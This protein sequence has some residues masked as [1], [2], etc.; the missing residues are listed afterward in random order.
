MV[1]GETVTKLSVTG[2]SHVPVEPKTLLKIIARVAERMDLTIEAAGHTREGKYIFALCSMR[3]MTTVGE[4]QF[5]QYLMISTSNEGNQK[6]RITPLCLNSKLKVQLPVLLSQRPTESSVNISHHYT[7]DADEV[8]IELM[9]KLRATHLD[10][11]GTL[12][13]LCEMSASTEDVK[14]FHHMIY[15]RFTVGKSIKKE[16]DAAM[17]ELMECYKAVNNSI[18]TTIKGTYLSI[19]LSLNHY[20][21]NIKKRRGGSTGKIHSLNF[22]ADE[23]TKREAFSDIISLLIKEG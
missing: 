14:Q 23:K 13:K 9:E 4:T 12:Q 20:L 5:N 19:W 7:L 6:T 8:V 1:K 10:Y 2:K 22:G 16:Y 21:D 17:L 15:R 18:D 11:E 3:S